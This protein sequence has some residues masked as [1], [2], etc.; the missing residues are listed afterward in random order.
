MDVVGD[1]GKGGAVDDHSA[2]VNGQLAFRNDVSQQVV[3]QD[4]FTALGIHMGQSSHFNPF[5]FFTEGLEALDTLRLVF[6]NGDDDALGL[7]ILLEHQDP[8][9]HFIC[10]IQ[11]GAGITG[12]I[13]FTFCTVDDDGFDL[14]QILHHELNCAGETCAALADHTAVVDGVDEALQVVNIW[15]GQGL[16]G[17]VAAI[18]CDG[19][20]FDVVASELHKVIHR[21]DGARDTGVDRCGDEA[22]GFADE[23]SYLNSVAA[24]DYRHSRNANV[25]GH[26]NGDLGRRRNP[27]RSTARRLL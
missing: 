5:G 23:L 11:H 3:D 6:F 24:L 17:F 20:C 22:A 18:G 26:G 2:Y 10:A 12:D 21:S 7:V 19:D 9:P 14:V 25:H 1:G 4:L 16:Q 13:G 27:F 8:V 15:R